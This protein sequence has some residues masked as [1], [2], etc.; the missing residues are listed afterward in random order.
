MCAYLE[1][2]PGRAPHGHQP[3]PRRPAWLGD[4]GYDSVYG[5]RPLK[6]VIQKSLVAPIARELL[7]GELADGAVIE[8]GADG[9]ALTVARARVH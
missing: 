4:R 3:E 5:A 2:S 7:S 8:V 9:D 6:R 1:G